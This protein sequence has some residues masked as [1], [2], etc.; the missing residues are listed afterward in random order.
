MKENADDDL[1]ESLRKNLS[2]AESASVAEITAH[3]GRMLADDARGT[4]RAKV[5]SQ[6]GLSAGASIDLILGVLKSRLDREEEPEK[7][8]TDPRA[9]ASAR[10]EKLMRESSLPFM[11]AL[12][13]VRR[14]DPRLSEQLDGFYLGGATAPTDRG[15]VGCDVER[16]RRGS[17]RGVGPQGQ[18]AGGQR[19]GHELG[20]GHLDGLPTRQAPRRAAHEFLWR[21]PG[22]VAW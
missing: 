18:G 9:A 6:L 4:L 20:R 22:A 14:E 3:V 13:R 11:E 10:V 7:S 21:A 17:A 2:L 16:E 1:T 15:E 8:M 19:Q 12:E 5:A